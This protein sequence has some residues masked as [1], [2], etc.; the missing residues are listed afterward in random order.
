MQYSVGTLDA[1]DITPHITEAQLS[2]YRRIQAVVATGKL[3]DAAPK[4]GL[5][6]KFSIPLFS[7]SSKSPEDLSAPHVKSASEDASQ[8]TDL[9]FRTAPS[10]PVL[11]RKTNSAE[12]D[13]KSNPS[14]PRL[15]DGKSLT[16]ITVNSLSVHSYSSAPLLTNIESDHER[17]MQNTP[18][19]STSPL[20]ADSS[21]TSPLS[22]APQ[23]IQ[24]AFRD[25]AHLLW[26]KVT[27]VQAS[28]ALVLAN[29]ADSCA[30]SKGMIRECGALATL[31]ALLRSSNQEVHH[32][33]V[34][35]VGACTI[36]SETNR[37]LIA[38]SALPHLAT[39]I[40]S[41]NIEVKKAALRAIAEASKE[42]ESSQTQ[43]RS[44]RALNSIFHLIQQKP[45]IDTISQALD[46][47]SVLLVLSTE[48]QEALAKLGAIKWFLT[49]L[50][51]PENRV[52]H[53]N[54]AK[55][56]AQ[57][58]HNNPSVQE[59]FRLNGGIEEILNL[60]RR[61][62]EHEIPTILDALVSITGTNHASRAFIQANTG[63]SIIMKSLHSADPKQQR[64]AI[65]AFIKC[66]EPKSASKN[67]LF[68][69]RKTYMILEP[70]L[71]LG[72]PC[73]MPALCILRN[74]L[75]ETASNQDLVLQ[76]TIPARLFELLESDNPD[77]ISNT[78]SVIDSLAKKNEASQILLRETGCGLRLMKKM[79][80]LS[81]T[82][83]AQC[84]CLN[85]L[86]SCCSHDLIASQE[87]CR[88][89]VLLLAVKALKSY[90]QDIQAAAAL[91][92]L[93]SIQKNEFAS[94]YLRR[95]N[96]IPSLVPLLRTRDTVVQCRVARALLTA[97]ELDPLEICSA[98]RTATGIDSTL[99]LIKSLLESDVLPK[100]A[101]ASLS[102]SVNLDGQ[103]GESSSLDFL[104]L[105][106]RITEKCLVEDAPS[107]DILHKHNGVYMLLQF[108]QESRLENSHADVI[109]WACTAVG[110]A[111]IQ[112]ASNSAAVKSHQGVRLILNLH[113][114][115]HK[116]VVAS[117]AYSL[118]RILESSEDN[119]QE[120]GESDGVS[121]MFGLLKQYKCEQDI[122]IWI[123]SALHH[124]VNNHLANSTAVRVLGGFP[125]LVELLTFGGE[126]VLWRTARLMGYL[127]GLSDENRSGLVAAGACE[128]LK[129]LLGHRST[130]V[131]H[132]SEKAIEALNPK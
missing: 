4:E 63:I 59:E 86:A 2:S 22:Q 6:R 8:T 81:L 122:L 14:S 121:I 21:P 88:A 106:M 34:L 44:S 42:N 124:A 36:G 108:L 130:Y 101:A 93:N 11:S 40:S 79:E 1:F 71:T 115:R 27:Q 107:R 35:A 97:I 123:V 54:V 69:P 49:M 53:V 114:Y 29:C 120:F 94:D 52:V 128:A 43:L 56:L 80:V 28:V 117:V 77:I 103:S 51:D 85:A 31:I 89:G 20:R 112:H 72:D 65:F 30:E 39:L 10:S 132:F 15:K 50:E 16:N 113:G 84:C 23:S 98:V 102:T 87:L 37:R 76:T 90:R 55:T 109:R 46:T 47:L 19:R 61:S 111:C 75:S 7:K 38:A 3:S 12:S 125:V 41:T 26:H 119:K 67:V 24:I 60:L 33:A 96:A 100:A 83:D 82:L 73:C 68:N 126:E 74:S 25:M 57:L 62:R 118:G 48:N 91:L 45:E 131:K 99:G 32:A 116:A 104:L 17:L 5:R 127:A 110:S 58:C 78:A 92:I 64:A 9:N 129:V 18:S 70:Y 66:L 13:V 105:L 95:A